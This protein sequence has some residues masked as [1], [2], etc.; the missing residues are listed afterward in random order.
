MFYLTSIE[1]AEAAAERTSFLVQ[2]NRELVAWSACM[3]RWEVSERWCP[4][5]YIAEGCFIAAE[6]NALYD[7]FGEDPR[8]IMKRQ[9]IRVERWDDII[10]L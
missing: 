3:S 8:D 7:M 1:L 10:L 5:A 4:T 2:M 6:L 9:S